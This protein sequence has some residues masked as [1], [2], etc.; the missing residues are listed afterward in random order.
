MA[1]SA[2]GRW[3]DS[4]AGRRRCSGVLRLK[5][6]GED[7]ASFASAA[8]SPRREPAPG[9]W[10]A[11]CDRAGERPRAPGRR[12]LR[13]R[14]WRACRG[15]DRR[16]SGRRHGRH[17]DRW[18]WGRLAMSVGLRHS[19]IGFA[20][21]AITPTRRQP[22]TSVPAGSHLRGSLAART[23]APGGDMLTLSTLQRRRRHLRRGDRRRPP[24]RA[25]VRYELSIERRIGPA[26]VVG[27]LF[28]EGTRD[29][30]INAYSEGEAGRVLRVFNGRGL[31]SR[32][33]GVAVSRN[34]GN[35]LSGAFEYTYGHSWRDAPLGP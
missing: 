13:L 28:H 25:D 30:L 21:T 17:D 12:W 34:F 29:Q 6:M 24:A 3:T 9:G 23:L 10:R 8:W 20:R 33:G 31:S 26:R 15:C 14:R 4:T 5:G 32:G 18:P 27:R 19:Y 22:S 11:S 7:G 2:W 35:A 16:K 1:D